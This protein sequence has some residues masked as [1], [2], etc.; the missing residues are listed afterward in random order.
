MVLQ[1]HFIG[2]Q[3]GR[4]IHYPEDD[5]LEHIFSVYVCFVCYTIGIVRRY[6]LGAL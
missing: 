4:F 1:F 3:I 6:G 2:C 5:F